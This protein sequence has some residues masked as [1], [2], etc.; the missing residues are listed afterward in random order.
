MPRGGRLGGRNVGG[1]EYRNVV[2]NRIG[3]IAPHTGPG[4]EEAEPIESNLGRGRWF[5]CGWRH[6]LGDDSM[7][8]KPNMYGTLR[9]S[10]SPQGREGGPCGCR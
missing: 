5:G 7:C 9:E 4:L 10:F 1:E 3:N 6:R 8:Q 2:F